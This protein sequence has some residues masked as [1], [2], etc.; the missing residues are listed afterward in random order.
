M[1]RMDIFGS[2]GAHEQWETRSRSRLVAAA[3]LPPRPACRHYHTV[4]SAANGEIWIREIVRQLPLQI[5]NFSESEVVEGV[6]KLIVKMSS[7]ERSSM[8]E[9][10]G[11]VEQLMECKQLTENQVRGN[12]LK[13]FGVLL[14]RSCSL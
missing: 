9:L 7:E 2:G 8:K 1:R 5:V 14:L 4:R 13:T 12:A 3:A 10:D 6:S 11:W